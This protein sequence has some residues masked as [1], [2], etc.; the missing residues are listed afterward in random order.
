MYNKFFKH[1]IVTS[2]FVIAQVQ[3]VGSIVYSTYSVLLE[4]MPSTPVSIID[5]GTNVF[6]NRHNSNSNITVDGYRSYD[7]DFPENIMR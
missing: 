6:I 4:V 3:V 7:P 5:G 2:T 1:S